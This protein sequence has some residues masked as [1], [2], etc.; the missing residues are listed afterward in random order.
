MV[1]ALSLAE[2]VVY[3]SLESYPKARKLS[4][5]SSADLSVT[6]SMTAPCRAKQAL[7]QQ[8]NEEYTAKNI[9]VD[10]E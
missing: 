5:P 8:D 7:V 4:L 6:H 10:N 2:S 9:A 1:R 3:A